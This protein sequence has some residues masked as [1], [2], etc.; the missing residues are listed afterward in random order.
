MFHD[1]PVMNEKISAGGH[2]DYKNSPPF[3]MAR[4]TSLVKNKPK[5]VLPHNLPI[6]PIITNLNK[7][8]NAYGLKDNSISRIIKMI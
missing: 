6:I 8:C 2:F 1:N 4:V 7:T 3:L 5:I